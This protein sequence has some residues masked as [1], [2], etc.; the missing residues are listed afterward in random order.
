MHASQHVF[1][2]LQFYLGTTRLQLEHKAGPDHVV[3]AIA[4]VVPAFGFVGIPVIAW[5]LDKMGYGITLAT[6]NFLGVLASFFQAMPSVWFQACCHSHA[7]TCMYTHRPGMPPQ[8]R[9]HMH[10]CIYADHVWYHQASLPLRGVS[11]A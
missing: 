4:N 9:P 11:A 5:L 8:P 1:C 2:F 10:A 6:I 3:T 7:L